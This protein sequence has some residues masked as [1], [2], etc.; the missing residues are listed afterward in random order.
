MIGIFCGKG[1]Y[2]KIVVDSCKRQKLDFC[3]LFVDGYDHG[4]FYPDV[5]R[6]AFKLGQVGKVLQF[7]KL[8][9]VKKIT[10]A[11]HVKR[12]GLFD[13][14]LD[15]EGFRW[16]IRLWKVLLCGGDDA[17]LRG[18][19]DLLKEKGIELVS[20]TDLLKGAFFSEGIYSERK[21]TEEE[22]AEIE[23][24]VRESQ[25]L[26]IQD[27]GHSVIAKED[28]SGTDA[29][30]DRCFDGILVKTSKP[31]QDFRMDLPVI[32]VQTIENLHRHNFR[33]IVI[34]ADRTII[35]NKNEVLEKVDEY[36]LFL[37][38]IKIRKKHKVF[39]VAGESSGDYLGGRLMKDLR[40]IDEDIEFVG[41]GG[42]CMEEAGII[43]LC[44]ISK[45]SVIG[46]WE[47][48][49]KIFYFRDLINKTANTIVNYNPDV[50]V[51]IDSSGFTHRVDKLV[52]KKKS[53]I[54]IVHYVSPPVWAWRGWRAKDLHKFIDKL[55][56]LL[57]FEEDFLKNYGVNTVF[58]GHPV[59]S[60]ADFTEDDSL[61]SKD[62]TITLLPGSRPSE[63]E[64]HMPI[65]KEFSELIIEKHPEVRFY[66]PTVK[67]VAPLIK[68]YVAN[69][70]YKP[71]VSTK[72]LKKVKAYNSSHVAVA[73]SGTVTLELAKMGL[74]FVAIYKT[75]FVT[76]KLVEWLIKIPYVCLV[77]ILAGK[78]LVPELLQDECTAGNIAGAVENILNTD[79]KYQ[80]KNDFLKIIKSL[81]VDRMKS[82][83][84]VYSYIQNKKDV[85]RNKKRNVRPAT[86]P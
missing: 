72:K 81:K 58:V 18:I 22:Q 67:T 68:R 40:K 42:P 27:I 2:P 77:N 74:P 6:V 35:L 36:G 10:F 60:D 7:L 55:M 33:G 66:L 21:P 76:A 8:N 57:P 79:L 14:S 73:A 39:I 13:L 44:P 59:A 32:G 65:L 1:E 45:L 83:Q 86:K 51:T 64:H 4:L 80:Q 84:E 48:I 82:A 25:M 38:A 49:G 26:G 69:W 47:V 50:L 20:G 70:K 75:S 12:P 17:L 54:P 5:P 29:L 24:G 16:L 85:S 52:K 15:F 56:V 11:G 28:A 43:N 62:L 41:I 3:L 63:L 46:I 37:Q 61:K 19:A 9:N 23:L 53:D 34:E 71:T 78:S 30:I 31:Q